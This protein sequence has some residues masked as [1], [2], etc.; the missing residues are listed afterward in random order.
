MPRVSRE[1]SR[2]STKIRLR[3]AAV[4]EFARRGVAA[5]SIDRIAG[6][7]GFSRGAFYAN[8]A[9]KWDLLLELVHESNTAE[10]AVWTGLIEQASDLERIMDD[11]AARFDCY[12]AR[13]DFALL[14]VEFQLEAARNPKFRVLHREQSERLLR[15]VEAMLQLLFAKAGRPVPGDLSTLARTLRALTL[16][17]VMQVTDCDADGTRG[18]IVARFLRSALADPARTSADHTK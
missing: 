4:G 14:Q 13:T 17:L 5:A 18:A 2:I 8:Y 9:G 15:I 11:L 1:Q 7:A 12:A 10:V 16:G 6:N 3:G